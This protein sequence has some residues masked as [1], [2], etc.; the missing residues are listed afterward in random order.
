MRLR[1]A[2]LVLAALTVL[3]GAACGDDADD[4]APAAPAPSSSAV[5]SAE[6]GPSAPGT[7]AA[8]GSSADPDTV[9]TEGTSTKKPPKQGGEANQGPAGKP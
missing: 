2:M 5:P 9:P 6:S 7:S 8:P 4:K 3:T 1:H